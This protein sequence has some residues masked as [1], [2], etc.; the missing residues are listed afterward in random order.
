MDFVKALIDNKLL[1]T[2]SFVLTSGKI[3]PYY[4]DLRRLSNY[5]DVFSD[6]VNKAIDKIKKIE[7]DM[8]I[9][10]ATGGVP[11]ASFI[12]CRIGK[13]LGYIRMERKGYGTDKILEADVK[14]KRIVLVDDV[15]TTGGS[16][17]KAVEAITSEGGRV[18]AS[19]VIV[20]REEGA[21]K[22]L[23][24]Q[25]VQLISVYKIREILEYLLNSNLISENDKNNIREYLV[26]NI[27]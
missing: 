11:F 4:L 21:E 23:A 19:L 14:G 3:S 12:A 25:G 7:F 5:Y 13:P 15:A 6:T 16:L 1:L 20:D 18:V 8:V 27:G 10:I 22:K 26:K 9:G 2:G 24:E 17:S